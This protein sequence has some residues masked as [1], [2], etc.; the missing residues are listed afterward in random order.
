MKTYPLRVSAETIE[1]FFNNT[2]PTT[3]ENDFT[4]TGHIVVP[5]PVASNEA[6]TKGYVDTKVSKTTST[7]RLYGTT[8][9]GSQTTYTIGTLSGNIVKRE[10]GG[11][12]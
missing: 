7:N 3:F 2:S 11:N 8:N 10:S 9:G 4:F 6:A 12:I 1:S 5:T